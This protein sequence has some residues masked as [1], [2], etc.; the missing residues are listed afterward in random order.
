MKPFEIEGESVKI[1]KN[2]GSFPKNKKSNLK[3]GRIRRP[4]YETRHYISSR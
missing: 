2:S 3:N 1:T 4:K